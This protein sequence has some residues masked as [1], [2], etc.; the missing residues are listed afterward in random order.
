[1]GKCNVIALSQANDYSIPKDIS[2]LS[3]EAARLR[4][5]ASE[6]KAKA[7]SVAPQLGKIGTMYLRYQNK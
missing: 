4:L 5:D 7:L 3:K 2:E 6:R 1:M